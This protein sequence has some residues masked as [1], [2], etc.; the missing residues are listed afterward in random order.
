MLGCKSLGSLDSFNV[1]HSDI[2]VDWDD[3]ELSMVE[4]NVRTS[5]GRR[6]PNEITN[7]LDFVKKKDY[8]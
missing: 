5:E 2:F 6:N 4:L 3:I 7:L 1:Q 8:I